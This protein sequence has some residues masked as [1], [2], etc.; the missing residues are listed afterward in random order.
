LFAFETVVN[1]FSF[2][3]KSPFIKVEILEQTWYHIRQ[4]SHWI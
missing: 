1:V 3:I 2:H 4:F